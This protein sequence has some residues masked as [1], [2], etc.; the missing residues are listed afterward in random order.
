MGAPGSGWQGSSRPPGRRPRSRGSREG[1]RSFQTLRFQLFWSPG[2]F[3]FWAGDTLFFNS[4][5]PS[6]FLKLSPFWTQNLKNQKKFQCCADSRTIGCKGTLT[7]PKK[8]YRR[9]HTVVRGGPLDVACV[10]LS[11]RT[12]RIRGCEASN[13]QS[14]LLRRVLAPR[15]SVAC[16]LA[17]RLACDATLC[18]AP[19]SYP[20]RGSVELSPR[21][22]HLG[23]G[24]RAAGSAWWRSRGLPWRLPHVGLQTVIVNDLLK[25]FVERRLVST[26]ELPPTW[27]ST[28]ATSVCESTNKLPSG[29]QTNTHD[30]HSH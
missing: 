27:M 8:T 3:L 24:C 29:C 26:D 14:H 1:P 28:L 7:K 15:V 21:T 23:K 19:G 25:D 2:V 30:S 12:G 18:P 9:N 20:A 16:L 4:P 5:D 6:N 13:L 22:R 10:V 17:C 11:T